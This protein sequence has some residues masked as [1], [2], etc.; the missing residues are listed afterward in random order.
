MQSGCH[1][2]HDWFLQLFQSRPDLDHAIY[3]YVIIAMHEQYYMH[4]CTVDSPV[5][6]TH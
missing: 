2:Y 4:K 6:L 3:I 1:N 5:F